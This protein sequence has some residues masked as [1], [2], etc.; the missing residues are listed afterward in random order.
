MSSPVSAAPRPSSIRSK[1]RAL[2]FQALYEA[3]EASH[4]PRRAIEHWLVEEPLIKSAES[5]ARKLIQGVVD[6]RNS[7]DS[8][9]SK[10]APNWPVGQISVVDRNILRLAI[11]EIIGDEDTPPKAA[12]NEA[13][14][15]CKLFGSESSP[16]FI[17]G[18][19]GSIMRAY[20]TDSES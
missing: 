18:V 4:D 15:L 19:L 16:K 3:D 6:K 20:G 9:I 11:Y 13:I 17:N 14:E 10:Y 1:A 5:F 8:L 2:A 7:I 12:I